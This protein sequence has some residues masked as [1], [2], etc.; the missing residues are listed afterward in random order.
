M[1]DKEED[2]RPIFHR[3]RVHGAKSKEAAEGMAQGEDHFMTDNDEEDE[4]DE[5]EEGA[6]DWNLS[7]CFSQIYSFFQIKKKFY[8]K[9]IK[10]Y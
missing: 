6:S 5:E 4:D 9:I 8:G 2:M 7:N 3:S 10:I 1:P